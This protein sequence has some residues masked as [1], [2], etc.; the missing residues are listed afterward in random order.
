MLPVGSAHS[1][2]ELSCTVGLIQGAALA[3]RFSALGD[4]AANTGGA[5][6][7]ITSALALRAPVHHRHQLVITEALFNANTYG[8]AVTR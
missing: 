3:E 8:Q 7:R 6:F 1:C 2:P 4:V 5:L